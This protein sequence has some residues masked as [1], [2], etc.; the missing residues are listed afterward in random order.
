ME[1]DVADLSDFTGASL[2]RTTEPVA[3]CPREDT[4]CAELGAAAHA[5]TAL[6]RSHA[7][8]LIR[9]IL[10]HPVDDL[11]ILG[12]AT[13]RGVRAAGAPLPRAPA[14]QELESALRTA[15]QVAW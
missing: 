10:L 9:L 1:G 2:T 3:P 11:N 7:L 15:G 14:Y 4:G 5:V 8:A 6:Y 13:S 12:V